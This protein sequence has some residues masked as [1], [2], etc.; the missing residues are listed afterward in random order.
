MLMFP[1]DSVPVILLLPVAL[2]FHLVSHITQWQDTQACVIACP[3]CLHQKQLELVEVK[4][5]KSLAKL[6]EVKAR[7]Y[8]SCA[9]SRHED[10]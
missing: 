6:H 8:Q 1:G 4:T 2:I 7:A 3:S 5:G 10:G 9:N